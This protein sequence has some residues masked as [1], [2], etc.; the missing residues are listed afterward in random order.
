MTAPSLRPLRKISPKGAAYRRNE[1]TERV[2]LELLALPDDALLARCEIL[3]RDV[4]GYVPGECLV[5]LV[6][7]GHGAAGR[8]RE[9]IF[10]ILAERVRNRLPRRSGSD[11]S[12]V[13]LTGSNIADE[14]FN[15]FL[16]L[17]MSDRQSYDAGLD[18]WEVCFDKTLKRRRFDAQRKV[19][20]YNKRT[21]ALEVDDSTGDVS[22]ELRN[23]GGSLQTNDLREIERDARRIDVDAAIDQLPDLQRQILRLVRRGF[24]LYSKDPNT[25][26]VSKALEKSD[27]TIRSHHQQAI[28][29]IKSIIDG[30]NKS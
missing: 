27:K 7:T 22:E 11:G 24:P 1:N 10:A 28:A 4:A 13:S 5:Y 14:V 26:C 9:R 25:F 18:A 30:E 12:A 6:R 29:T 16:T 19:L 17:L 3:S 21:P 8:T 23:Q 20:R 15:G 2:L